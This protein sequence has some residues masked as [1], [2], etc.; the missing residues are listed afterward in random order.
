MSKQRMQRAETRAGDRA[1]AVPPQ[2]HAVPHI[3]LAPHGRLQAVVAGLAAPA[4]SAHHMRE[5]AA[6][7]RAGITALLPRR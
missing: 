5:A 4:G 2:P 1:T 6:L 3:P 7:A